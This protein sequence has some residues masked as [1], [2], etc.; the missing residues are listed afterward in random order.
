[1]M[2]AEWKLLLHYL[3]MGVFCTDISIS[4]FYSNLL[5]P[6][7]FLSKCQ[8]KQTVPSPR[9]AFIRLWKYSLIPLSCIMIFRVYISPIIGTLLLHAFLILEAIL[10]FED[11]LAQKISVYVIYI[12]L[13]TLTETTT[14]FAMFFTVHA[15]TGRN[16]LYSQVNF[17]DHTLDMV[18]MNLFY[19]LF[20]CLFIYFGTIILLRF[21]QNIRFRNVALLFAPG[22]FVAL[23]EGL[24]LNQENSPNIFA[25]IILYVLFDAFCVLLFFLNLRSIARRERKHE[26]IV[27]QSALVR[28]QLD[29]SNEIEE[30]YRV[31]RKQNHD[32]ANQLQSL[33]WMIKSRHYQEASAYLD[34]LIDC[35]N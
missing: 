7:K 15:L 35:K 33:T 34:E 26:M 11:K 30:K 28:Q 29:Y 23:G 1:M 13:L 20:C 4:Y 19:I 2:H 10:F 8:D 6:G 5:K 25:H 12:G 22:F 9:Q 32:I 16:I 27:K 18:I 31:I 3:F 24:L 21:G 17:L 14:T